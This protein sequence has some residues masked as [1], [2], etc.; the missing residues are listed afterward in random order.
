MV[1]PTFIDN[2]LNITKIL[3]Y[4]KRKMLS[5]YKCVKMETFREYLL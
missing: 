2:E 4:F 1:F 3:N 5:I